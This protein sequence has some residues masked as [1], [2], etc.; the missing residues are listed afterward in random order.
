MNLDTLELFCSVVRTQSFSR[1]A[2]AMSVSQSA[3]SQAVAQL[4]S[5]L[6][7]ALIDRSKRPFILTAE[8][9]KFYDGVHGLIESYAKL[10]EDV[11]AQ[12]T[13]VSGLVRVAAIYSIG[14]HAMSRHV[15]RFM[16]EHPRAKVR[17][18]Y[19]RPNMV[20]ESV[21]NDNVDLGIVSFPPHS[22]ALNVVPLRV[23]RMVLVC[24]PGHRL[25][26]RRS[27]DVEDL[28]GEDMITFDRDLTIRRAIDRVL[29]RRHVDVNVVME[30]D[31]IE[32]IKLALVSGAG[33]AI[34]PEPTMQRE[35][36]L[37]ALVTRPLDV[38]DLERPIGIIHR[39]RRQLTPVAVKFIAELKSDNVTP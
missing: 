25:A 28:A 38:K 35:V 29:R 33:I 27:I 22:R 39:R 10:V 1:G 21:L 14:I 18:E 30:F 34:L 13:E 36:E 26:T 6:G 9:R 32:N 8:G 4:E 11:T 5:S 31:N 12:R 19:L 23:E 20:V 16:A 3:A 7:V 2:R 15:Q 17:M 37:R 24:P